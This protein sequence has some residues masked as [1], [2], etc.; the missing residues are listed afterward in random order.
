MQMLIN[1]KVEIGGIM[2]VYKFHLASKIFTKLKK[3][4]EEENIQRFLK[5]III[6][7]KK[8]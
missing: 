8:Y 7:K 3:N 4:L 1:K 2:K 6:I 5:V